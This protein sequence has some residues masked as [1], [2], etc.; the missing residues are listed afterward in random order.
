MKKGFTLIELI[1]VLL[2]FSLLTL[3]SII[4]L[5]PMVEGFFMVRQNTEAA[6]RTQLTM[7]RLMVEMQ[8]IT[9]V[10]SSGSQTITYDFLDPA[11]VPHR[12]VLAWAGSGAPLTLNN[13]VLSDDVGSFELRYLAHPTGSR[14]TSW[15][16][17][18]RMIEVVLASA[19]GGD[20]YTN[21]V[22]PRNIPGG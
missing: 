6:Q 18:S 20:I 5:L 13:V 4:A 12:R 14:T 1:V 9:N 3:A 8:T 10:V 19:R 22:R 7:G 17:Q 16:P 11:G 21:R 15:Q 2:L